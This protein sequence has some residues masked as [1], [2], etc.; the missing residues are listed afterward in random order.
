MCPTG[1][2]DLVGDTDNR[3]VKSVIKGRPEAM[4]GSSAGH[5]SSHLKLLTAVELRTVLSVGVLKHSGLRWGE[6]REEAPRKLTAIQARRE[7]VVEEAAWRIGG[8]FWRQLADLSN[9]HERLD[10]GVGPEQLEV[11]FAEE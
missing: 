6:K 2:Y 4:E 11:P 1:S 10:L 9:T 3:T 7:R 8:I 5:S